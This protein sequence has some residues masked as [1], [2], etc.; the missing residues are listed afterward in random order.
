MN[1]PFCPGN[2]V[3]PKDKYKEYIKKIKPNN[4]T[5]AKKKY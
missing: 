3:F 1:F 4:Y 2:K 5:K